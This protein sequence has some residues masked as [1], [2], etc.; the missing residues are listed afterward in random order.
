MGIEIEGMGVR[1]PHKAGIQELENIFGLI[2]SH[3]LFPAE[4]RPG[5]R[6]MGLELTPPK[7]PT[8][9][10][11]QPCF[12]ELG[13]NEATLSGLG[14]GSFQTHADNRIVHCTEI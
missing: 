13:R 10:Q 8:T 14:A 6:W 3:Q 7:S 2:Y 5:G 12:C 9:S 11:G 4:L 1:A